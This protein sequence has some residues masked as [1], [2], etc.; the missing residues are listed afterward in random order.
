MLLR[1]SPDRQRGYSL[2]EAL[3]VVSI[4]GVISLVT[5]PNFINYHRSS[6]LRSSIRNF[7]SD[8]R[9]IRQLAV[10]RN[11]PTMMSIG[12]SEP[13][14][15]NYWLY[16]RVGSAWELRTPIGGKRLEGDAIHPTIYFSAPADT[17]GDSEQSDGRIDIVFLPN[18]AVRDIGSAPF[19]TNPEVLV[20]T[21][22][23]LPRNT[24]TVTFR[25][26]GALGVN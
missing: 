16:E 15:Y 2:I 6:K 4:I 24:Y 8:V 3:V 19:P 25:R 17:F 7:T 9:G 12:T 14:K 23:S 1:R 5:I 20:K 26:S 11:V 10:T 22:A 21:D 18:G 13:E